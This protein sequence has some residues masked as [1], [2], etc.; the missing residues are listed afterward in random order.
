MN[1]K[2]RDEFE[3]I[4]VVDSDNDPYGNAIIFTLGHENTDYPHSMIMQKKLL[5]L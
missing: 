5:I 3:D 4:V 2:I 1:L